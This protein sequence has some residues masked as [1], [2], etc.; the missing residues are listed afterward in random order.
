M[1]KTNKFSA[2]TE[3]EKLD[4]FKVEE[5]EPRLEMVWDDGTCDGGNGS[6]CGSGGGGGGTGGGGG[7]E[8][9][10]L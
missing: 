3:K 6:S 10:L 1:N 9:Q 4:L 7:V 2:L 5:L 8:Q